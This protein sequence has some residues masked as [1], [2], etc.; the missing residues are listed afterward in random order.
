MRSKHYV[1]IIRLPNGLLYIMRCSLWGGMAARKPVKA[2]PLRPPTALVRSNVNGASSAPYREMTEQ[3]V[4][5]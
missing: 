3:R 4:M 1:R 2:L 5:R